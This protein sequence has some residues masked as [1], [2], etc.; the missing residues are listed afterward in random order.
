MTLFD[1]STGGELLI[2][3]PPDNSIVRFIEQS[4][5]ISSESVAEVT[6]DDLIVDEHQSAITENRFSVEVTGAA[7]ESIQCPEG[8]IS[9]ST[10]SRV[11]DGDATITVELPTIKKGKRV[12]FLVISNLTGG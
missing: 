9:G 12:A 10:V 1:G 8:S 7:V 4:V 6:S 3:P 11:S 5:V 2:G